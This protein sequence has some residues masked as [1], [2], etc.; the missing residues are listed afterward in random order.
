MSKILIIEDDLSVRTGLAELLTEEGH[1]IIEAENGV[2]GIKEAQCKLP[3]LIISDIR[4]PEADGYQVLSELQK[5]IVT[6]GIPFIFL[7]AK[8]DM[9][10]IRLGMNLG[11]DDYLIKPYKAEHLISAVNSKLKHKRYIDQKFENLHTTIARSLPH[12][13]RTPLVSILGFSQ[14]ILEQ[15]AEFEKKEILEMAGNINN[16]GANLLKIIKKFLLYSDLELIKADK[17][18][19]SLITSKSSVHSKFIYFFIK[20]VIELHGR[21]EDVI[22]HL[23]DAELNIEHKHL[24]FIIEELVDNACKFSKPGSKISIDSWIEDNYMILTIKDFGVGMSK[25]QLKEIGVMKQFEREKY[26]QNGLGMSLAVIRNLI[27]LYQCDIVIE[28]IKGEYTAVKI[29]FKISKENN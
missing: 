15:K 9:E 27:E 5:E 12:E 6:A 17:A 28:S 16:A 7:S 13:M 25:E 4:M 3:D 20:A 26:F 14:L 23:E 1:K 10:D 21:N 8:T 24:K 11:A 2:A 18:L 22:M 19:S 29:L